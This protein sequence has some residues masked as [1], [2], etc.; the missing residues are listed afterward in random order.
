MKIKIKDLWQWSGSISRAPFVIW[1]L[2]LFAL[3]YNLDRLLVNMPQTMWSMGYWQY[4][5]DQIIHAIHRRVL[6]H[7]KEL[8]KRDRE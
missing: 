1:A 4:W 3:K 7:V 6:L 2:I 8:T 5:S